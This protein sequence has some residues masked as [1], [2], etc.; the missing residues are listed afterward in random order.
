MP[1]DALRVPTELPT[2]GY[3][4]GFTSRAKRLE[5]EAISQHGSVAFSRA[6]ANVHIANAEEARNRDDIKAAFASIKLARSKVKR[7]PAEWNVPEAAGLRALDGK[8]YDRAR[9]ALLKA[10]RLDRARQARLASFVAMSIEAMDRETDCEERVSN[11]AASSFA[12][13]ASSSAAAAS[14]TPV[15][16]VLEQCL[17]RTAALQACRLMPGFGK[18]IC[19]SGVRAKYSGVSCP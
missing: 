2:P 8:E 15:A 17:T 9:S 6:L 11:Q 19:K 18:D 4:I 7:G 12:R 5:Q 16:S 1:G 10:S 3:V 14:G 13:S